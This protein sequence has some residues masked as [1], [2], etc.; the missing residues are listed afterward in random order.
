VEVVPV[1]PL[2]QAKGRAGYCVAGAG[3]GAVLRAVF[4]F[5][6]FFLAA[7]FFGA[8]AGAGF[9]TGGGGGGTYVSPV[10]TRSAIK[11]VSTLRR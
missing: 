4:V 11:R 1:V 9:T 3:A 7:I 5:V 6:F 10:G 2:A 8:G